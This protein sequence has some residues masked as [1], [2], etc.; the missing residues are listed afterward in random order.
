MVL[1]MEDYRPASLQPPE[2][3]EGKYKAKWEN[4]FW[5]S[6]RGEWRGEETSWEV[7]VRNVIWI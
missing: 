6:I 5:D 2:K 1:A 3:S 4:L 7:L